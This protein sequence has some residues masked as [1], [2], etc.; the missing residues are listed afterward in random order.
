MKLTFHLI[1]T[2]VALLFSGLTAT[3]GI[4][5]AFC[6]FRFSAISEFPSLRPPRQ[7]K[8]GKSPVSTGRFVPR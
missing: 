4:G 5:G 7:L 3:A 8:V 1:A 6:L 2:P